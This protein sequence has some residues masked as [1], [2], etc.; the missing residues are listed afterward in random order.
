MVNAKVVLFWGGLHSKQ[1]AL[2]NKR[3]G[4]WMSGLISEVLNLDF[5]VC[6]KI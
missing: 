6:S 2:N 4:P 3:F 1:T 5:S